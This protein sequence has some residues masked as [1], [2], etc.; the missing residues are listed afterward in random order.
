MSIIQYKSS[1]ELAMHAVKGLQDK[2]GIE[3][4]L[5]NLKNTPN[6]VTDY[7]VIAS[8]SSDTHVDAL[9]ISV[10]KVLNEECNEEPMSVEGR[11][12]REWILLDYGNVIIH[13][14]KESAR[15]FYALE[16]LWG[17]AE[18]TKIEEKEVND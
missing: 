8:G 14:F 11:T 6:S 4:V 13:V 10:D 2:K 5:I 1:D 3:I 12:N 15:K 16:Q 7:F 9:S 17:D 18:I